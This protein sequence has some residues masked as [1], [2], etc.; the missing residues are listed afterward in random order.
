VAKVFAQLACDKECGIGDRL[1]KYAAAQSQNPLLHRLAPGRTA[2]VQRCFSA[3]LR[4][5]SSLSTVFSASEREMVATTSV[6]GAA[7]AASVSAWAS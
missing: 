3:L 2:T 1:E 4:L 5:T 7:L 6:R